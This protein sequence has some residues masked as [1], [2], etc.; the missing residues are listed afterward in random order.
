MVR[1]YT[2]RRKRS[3][4]LGSFR[5][6]AFRACTTR[7]RNSSRTKFESADRPEVAWDSILGQIPRGWFGILLAREVLE[8]NP[9]NF[10]S[11]FNRESSGRSS[12]SQRSAGQPSEECGQ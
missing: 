4:K 1:K 5:S 6:D 10:K 2:K 8:T 9:S 7:R 11:G 3:P 12:C